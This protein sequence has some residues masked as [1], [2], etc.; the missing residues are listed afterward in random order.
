[1]THGFGWKRGHFGLE[2]EKFNNGGSGAT[3]WVHLDV[4]EFGKVNLNEK[5]FVKK[6]SLIIGKKLTEY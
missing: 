1:M 4:R 6:Q 2:P 5:L 3:T